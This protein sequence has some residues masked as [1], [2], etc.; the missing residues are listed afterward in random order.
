M[1]FFCSSVGDHIE[2][3]FDPHEMLQGAIL[4]NFLVTFLATL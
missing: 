2:K 3:M 4:R 1:A